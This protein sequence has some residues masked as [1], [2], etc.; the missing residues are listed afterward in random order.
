M[1][2]GANILTT[3]PAASSA[4]TIRP[5]EPPPREAVPPPPAGDHESSRYEGT[6]ATGAKAAADPTAAEASLD[7][8]NLPEVDEA[9]LWEV[10]DLSPA[11][12]DEVTAEIANEARAKF[13]ANYRAGLDQF[14]EEI[15]QQAILENPPEV[16][17]QIERVG[18]AEVNELRDRLLDL[19]ERLAAAESD[20]KI[21][22]ED[23][24]RMQMQ[25]AR[26]L[27]ELSAYRAEHGS[28]LDAARAEELDEL[29]SC[30]Q[31]VAPKLQELRVKAQ[32]WRRLSERLDQGERFLTATSPEV[33]ETT[34][35]V[36]PRDAPPPAAPDNLAAREEL[37]ELIAEVREA[38][39][40]CGVRL[41]VLA[42]FDA[43]VKHGNR[44]KV[45]RQIQTE[46]LRSE[47]R[48]RDL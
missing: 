39:D 7:P 15:A 33:G 23:V 47:L 35:M 44:R 5:A 9:F 29:I 24:M 21:A 8:N 30:L 4:G 45:R 12:I 25:V 11:S 17:E 42:R 32:R 6:A 38:A 36:L 20:P 14:H 28:E 43:K 31:D 10:M 40:K 34:P 26:M 18:A 2:D 16:L 27:Q 19:R 48:R 37:A 41:E 22:Q 13:E 1:G 46:E 3:P